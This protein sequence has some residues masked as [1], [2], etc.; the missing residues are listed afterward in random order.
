MFSVLS[1][2]PIKSVKQLLLGSILITLTAC[3]DGKGDEKGNGKDPDRPNADTTAPV[4]TLNGASSLILRLGDEYTEAGAT[5]S[6]NV[7]G[8]V[9]VKIS[10]VVNSSVVGQYT[11]SYSATDKAGNTATATRK[12]AVEEEKPFITTWDTTGSGVSGDNKIRIDTAGTGYSYNVSW[13]DG[14]VSENLTG[15]AEHTYTKSGVYKI[16]ITGDFPQLYMAEVKKKH[17]AQGKFESYEYQSDNQKLLSVE[18]WGNI[19]W[20]SMESAFRST[21]VS[22]T[23]S[24][25]PNLAEVKDMSYL[26]ACDLD[27]SSCVQNVNLSNWDVSNVTDMS[28]MFYNTQFNQ[29]IS[30]WDVS[31]VTNMSNMFANARYFNRSIGEWDVSGLV[32]MSNMFYAAQAFNQDIGEW[33]LSSVQNLSGAFANATSFDQDISSWDVSSVTNMSSMFLCSATAEKCNFNQAVDKWD[34][35][36]VTDMSSMFA[37]ADNFNQPLSSWDVSNVKNMSKMFSG[38]DVFDQDISGWKVSSV[39]EIHEMFYGASAFNQDISSWDV[40]NVTN[41]TLLFAEA[42]SF[43]QNISRWNMSK[44]VNTSYMFNN[45][46]S[47][48]QDLSN[49]NVSSVTNMSYM[50]Y[51]ESTKCEFN[52]SLAQWDV[53]NV[54]LMWQMFDGITLTTTNYSNTLEAWSDL[55]LQQNVTLHAGGSKY[56]PLGRFARERII[57]QFNW[58]IEDAGFDN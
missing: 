12:V 42:K 34:V 14:S 15:T 21:K 58:T 17:D 49:W 30:S 53:S 45:A 50:F 13:G 47:F 52:Q 25:T 37:N 57:N 16:E 18:Q 8:T 44:V 11:I 5:A 33:K 19:R 39:T 35:S 43:N 31:K 51:C 41:M 1:F 6:D 26:F 46:N 32:D 22:F 10:G 9:D 29:P 36:S 40:S 54:K 23:A 20:Q 7:D 56:G 28:F 2:S 38:N 27:I 24:D 3:G 4:I 55:T 48:N